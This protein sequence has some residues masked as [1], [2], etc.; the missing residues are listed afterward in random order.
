MNS[1]IVNG[2]N[3]RR[4][5][6]S[7]IN[8]DESYFNLNRRMTTSIRESFKGLASRIEHD[9]SGSIELQRRMEEEIESIGKQYQRL[10]SHYQNVFNK[11]HIY[12]ETLKEKQSMKEGYE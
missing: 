11:L 12:T 3:E 10:N 7:F 4:A 5:E 9:P 1:R 2:F 8:N 6:P